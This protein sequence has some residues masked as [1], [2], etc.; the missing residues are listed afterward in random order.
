MRNN[1]RGFD[2]FGCEFGIVLVGGVTT[3][4]EL[5]RYRIS[6]GE[7]HGSRALRSRVAGHG[8]AVGGW[9]PVRHFT[10]CW[11]LEPGARCT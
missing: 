8:F 1:D 4:P 6:V 3:L 7:A 2:G 10:K 9:I 5:E 11:R